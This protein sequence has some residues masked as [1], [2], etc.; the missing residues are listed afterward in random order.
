LHWSKPLMIG[1]PGVNEAAVPQLVA[2]PQGQVA[3]S[4]YGSTNS[5]G[6]PFPPVCTGASVSC[7]G[8]QNETWSTYITETWNPLGHHP[9]FWSATLNHPTEPTWYGVTPSAL[10]QATGFSAGS[11]AGTQDC[12]LASLFARPPGLR[13]RAEWTISAWRSRRT[14]R[15]GSASYRSAPLAS[16]FR[17]TRTVRAR[18]PVAPTT[19]HSG[20]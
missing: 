10:R 5:P 6:P 1:A 14:P 13:S 7:P 17:V 8:Y 18:L 12:P 4:Y 9:V 3:V 19:G 16:L 15:R 11:D 20:L 2:G